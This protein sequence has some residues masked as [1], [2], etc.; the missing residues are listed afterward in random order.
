MGQLGRSYKKELFTDT[1]TDT[2]TDADIDADSDGDS[3]GDG[4][5]NKK[6]EGE[7]CRAQAL[8]GAVYI[9]GEACK[10]I[11]DDCA[12]GYAAAFKEAMSEIQSIPVN[13]TQNCAEGLDC[14]LKPDQCHVLSPVAAIMGYTPACQTGTEDACP[15]VG[16]RG[17]CP[18]E[19]PIC[20][21]G[22]QDGDSGDG[23]Q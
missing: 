18:P 21:F 14:C 1:Y 10:K 16:F 7:P 3:D 2:D 20:C 5:D 12:G 6:Q 22:P 11:G 23:G 9:M 13:V 8:A 4:D 15:G 17:A 19:K